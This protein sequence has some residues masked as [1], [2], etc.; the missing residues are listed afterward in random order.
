MCFVHLQ[1]I[2][3]FQSWIVWYF[4]FILRKL[5]LFRWNFRETHV[6]SV[7]SIQLPFSIQEQFFLRCSQMCLKWLSFYNNNIHTNTN[8]DFIDLIFI[9]SMNVY[10]IF[11]FYNSLVFIE[12]INVYWIY[13]YSILYSIEYT[14]F[15]ILILWFYIRSRNLSR[16]CYAQS[17][18]IDVL[19]IQKWVNP[20]DYIF[21]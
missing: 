4:K 17:N 11:W 15:Y 10:F 14:I 13:I 7:A 18:P 16:M 9:K 19:T 12:S 5:S 21:G 2:W 6:Y 3:F 20:S 8:I 1:E